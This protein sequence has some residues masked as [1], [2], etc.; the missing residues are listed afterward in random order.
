MVIAA[1][2]RSTPVTMTVRTVRRLIPRAAIGSPKLRN[3]NSS[4]R[5]ILMCSK[6][7]Q[8]SSARRQ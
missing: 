4:R 2:A 5:K 1:N 6:P 7:D 3:R 8:T